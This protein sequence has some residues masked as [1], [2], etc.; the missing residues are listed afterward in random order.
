[1]REIRC[2]RRVTIQIVFLAGLCLLAGGKHPNEESLL[3][4]VSA[5]LSE[6]SEDWEPEKVYI[7]MGTE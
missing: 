4:L 7:S 2:N 1:M 3:W 6:I 5:V